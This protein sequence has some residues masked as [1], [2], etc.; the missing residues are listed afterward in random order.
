MLHK[1]EEPGRGNVTSM[2]NREAKQINFVPHGPGADYTDPSYHLPAFYELW[3]R[4]AAAPADRAT[5]AQIT[6]TSREL[7]KKVAH[8][9]TGLMPDLCGFDGQ[10]ARVGRFE[11]AYDAWRTLSN[12]ALDHAWWAA[13]PWEVAQANRVLAFFTAQ[14]GA[15]VDRYQL[16]GTPVGTSANPSGLLAMT[17]TAALAADRKLGEPFVRR[18][19]D[20]ELPSGHYRYYNGLLTVI[21][22]LEVSGHFRIYAPPATR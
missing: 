8:P 10:P 14:G 1:D 11:F 20:A 17:A 5:L 9:R 15:C 4:W 3:A 16:D 22:L 18:L 19:W 2:F 21:A 6:A 7:L 13:D 12:P